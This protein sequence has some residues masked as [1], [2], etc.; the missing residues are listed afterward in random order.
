MKMIQSILLI[1]VCLFLTACSATDGPIVMGSTNL[2]GVNI[3][4]DRQDDTV[5]MSVNGIQIPLAD[6]EYPIFINGN[7]AE[8]VFVYDGTNVPTVAVSA[9]SVAVCGT[10]GFSELA[11]DGTELT[12]RYAPYIMANE[13]MHDD[14]LTNVV[15][16]AGSDVVQVDGKSVTLSA[17]VTFVTEGNGPEVYLPYQDAAAVFGLEVS[18]YD[19]QNVEPWAAYVQ[20]LD[21]PPYYLY[22][23]PHLMFWQYSEKAAAM[24]TEEAV[25]Q[26]REV[27][28]TAYE[29]RWV[30]YPPSDAAIDWEDA[31]AEQMYNIIENL[32]VTGQNDRFWRIPV[33]Y[34][35]L[36]DKYTG[37]IFTYYNGMAQSFAAF[38]PM[39]EWTLTFAG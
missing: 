9:M 12:L 27:L 4:T 22:C 2:D 17:P 32:E 24:S 39:S 21:S 13:A 6:H 28:I 36:V 11:A 8:S 30:E 5:S 20:T 16:T 14:D 33:V 38:D 37:D 26:V 25:R 29:N 3:P 1:V 34:D 23:V 10:S 7:L 18:F 15:F 19:A 35:F 31:E